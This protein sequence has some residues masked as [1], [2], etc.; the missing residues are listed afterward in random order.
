[1]SVGKNLHGAFREAIS[2]NVIIKYSRV[3]NACPNTTTT[4][5]NHVSLL[6]CASAETNAIIQLNETYL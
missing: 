2:N 5:L 1:M 6:N 4:V 3:P